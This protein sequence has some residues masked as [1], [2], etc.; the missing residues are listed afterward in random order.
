MAKTPTWGFTPQGVILL[1][2]GGLGHVGAIFCSWALLDFFW[3]LLLIFVN[4]LIDFKWILGGF[5]W[6][7]SGFWE[8]LGGM[9]PHARA[10]T[11]KPC[12]QISPPK[13]QIKKQ[14]HASVA[15]VWVDFGRILEILGKIWPCWGR[16][17]N[18]TPALVRSASQCAGVLPPA[19]EIHEL[20]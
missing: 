1:G 14:T 8:D 19:W 13:Q 2:G 6:I 4:F 5:G 3:V 12:C 17:S 15:C 9:F 18:W 20:K 10:I 16:F 11:K 7:W